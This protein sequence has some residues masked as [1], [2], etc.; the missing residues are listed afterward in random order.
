MLFSVEAQKTMKK[1]GK[2]MLV[3]MIH[4]DIWNVIS[5]DFL[6]RYL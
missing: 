3:Y 5:N 1:S 4:G 2:I 6:N